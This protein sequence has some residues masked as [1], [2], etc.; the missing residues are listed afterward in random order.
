[1][2][3]NYIKVKMIFIVLFLLLLV[4]ISFKKKT[5]VIVTGDA[6]DILTQAYFEGLIKIEDAYKQKS[7]TD[8]KKLQLIC[9]ALSELELTEYNF[10]ETDSLKVKVGHGIYELTY[11]DGS[12]KVISTLG[13]LI[14]L[15]E[16][17][18]EVRHYDANDTVGSIFQEQ[19]KPKE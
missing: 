8:I 7:I 5:T 10:T 13:T 11:L 15:D 19:F 16:G 9:Q 6:N 2:K 3:K 17:N 4:V 18:N 1:M 14:G 12:K